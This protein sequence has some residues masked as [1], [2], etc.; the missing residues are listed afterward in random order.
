[1]HM[2]QFEFKI[3]EDYFIT[4]LKKYRRQHFSRC[5]LIVIKSIASFFLLAL[6]ALTLYGRNWWISAFFIVLIVLL[7]KSH[8]IDIWLF[9]RRFRKSPYRNDDT[10][11]TISDDGLQEVSDKSESKVKWCLY[12]KACRFQDGFLIFQTQKSFD[13]LPDSAMTKGSTE[14]L[15]EIIKNNIKKYRIIK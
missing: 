2:I 8:L 7:F 3:D 10:L 6:S 11:I 13:W 15:E 5:I 12:V 4:A 1:M 9:K 14:D